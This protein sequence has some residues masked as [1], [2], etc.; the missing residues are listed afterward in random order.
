MAGWSNLEDLVKNEILQKEQEGCKVVGFRERFEKLGKDQSSL[1]TFYNE[2]CTLEQN[3]ELLKNEPSDLAGI[4]ANRPIGKRKLEIKCNERELQDKFYGAWLARSIGCALGKPIEGEAFMSGQDGRPGWKNVQLW[5]EGAD[6]WPIEGYTPKESRASEEYNLSLP[7]YGE[8]STRE[9]IAFMETDD[10]IRYTVLGLVM[11]ENKGLDWSSFDVG[12][13]WHS[14]LPYG[15]VCTAETQAYMN[16]QQ[17][18][19]HYEHEKPADWEEKLNWIRNYLNPYREW[20]GAQIRVDGYAYSTAGNL[21]LAAELAW[22]D[23]SFSHVRNGIYGSMFLGAAISSAFAESDPEKII[24][25]GLN[26]IPQYSRLSID[27]QKAVKFAKSAKNQLD[28][29]DKLWQEFNHYG[30][31]H[32]NNNAALCAA[33]IIF[34]NNDFEKAITT[35][36]LGWDTDCNGA[37]VGSIIGAVLG[38]AQI[39]E[40]WKAPLNDTL[41]S[42]I[43]GFHPIAISECAQRSYNMYKKL[44]K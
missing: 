40:K 1:I 39:P 30:A 7:T 17:V 21:E 5:F 11:L 31:V 18:T 29:A 33:S 14:K 26:E 24:E 19:H 6:A 34:A 9:K 42:D 12:K 23:A 32:T 41:Y 27:I 25:A 43:P 16:F 4:R 37:S 8:K 13:L 44:C 28:L 38:A 15:S 10:D 20:I 3:Q 36:V 2:L 35:S 22:R